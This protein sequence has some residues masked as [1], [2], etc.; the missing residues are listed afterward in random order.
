MID[1]RERL[2]RRM[3]LATGGAQAFAAHGD[4]LGVGLR[5]VRADGV[6]VALP[7]LAEATGA[8]LLVPPDRTIGIAAERLGQSR[9]RLARMKRR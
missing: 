1:H 7:E 6:G 8:G 3:N 9:P 5:P 2:R 4:D